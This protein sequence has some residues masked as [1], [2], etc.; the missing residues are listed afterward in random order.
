MRL[1]LVRHGETQWNREHRV[2]GQGDRPLNESGKKQAELIAIALHNERVEAIY[3]SPLRRALGTA[4]AINRFHR[5]AI[6]IIDGLKELDTGE[7][8]G[9][10]A[11]DMGV[12][13]PEFFR[14]WM[15]D[16]A[17]A[18]LPGG[19][20]LPEL[21]ER[22]WNSIQSILNNSHSN[23]VVVVSHLFAILSLF[24]KALDLNLSE[25]RRF[26]MNV[27]SVSILEL[28]GSKARLVSFNDT[29]HLE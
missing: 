7:L 14:I 22:V 21:Q 13:H 25:F 8:D 26:G 1:I 18:R 27:G 16:A 12:S 24:C 28:S 19:E 4:E 29:C 10:Y 5:V 17:L 11:S 23:T 15:A 2:Q 9:V 3:T 6:K 20:S